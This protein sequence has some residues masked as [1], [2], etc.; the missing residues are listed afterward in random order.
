MFKKRP[1]EGLVGCFREEPLLHRRAVVSVSPAAFAGEQTDQPK[2]PSIESNR[3]EEDWS[4]LADP[5]L[6]KEPLDWL[7]YLPLSA[8]DPGT[9]ISFGATLRE[10]F[11]SNHTP[12]FGIGGTVSDDYVLQRA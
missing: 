6:K 8:D 10:R 4:V 1:T 7:K 5:A 9:Y 12:A 11:E 2:R 3:R